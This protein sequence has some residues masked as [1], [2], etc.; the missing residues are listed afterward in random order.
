MSYLNRIASLYIILFAC[1]AVYAHA[2]ENTRLFVPSQASAATFNIPAVPG[3][4]YGTIDQAAAK[5]I[6]AQQ[7]VQVVKVPLSDSRVVTLSLHSFSVFTP[8]AQFYAVT[9]SG[10]VSM[11]PPDI[12]LYQGTVVGDDSSIVYLALGNKIIS[13]SIVTGGRHY[14]IGML[15]A[16]AQA[17]MAYQIYDMAKVP[18][19]IIQTSCAVSDKITPPGINYKTYD[20]QNGAS[21]ELD[22]NAPVA[23]PLAVQYSVS[24]AVDVDY[25]AYQFWNND[26]ATIGQYIAS[27]FGQINT[28][29]QNEA[30]V[31]ITIS[32]FRVWETADEPY[33]VQPSGNGFDQTAIDNAIQQEAT[34][35]Q[36]NMGS[37]SRAAVMLITKKNMCGDPVNAACGLGYMEYIDGS[38]DHLGVLC[39][40]SYGYSITCVSGNPAFPQE[41]ESV[42]AHE[43]G[44]N[45]GCHHTHSCFWVDSGYSPTPVDECAPAEDGQCFSGTQ[46]SVGTIMSYCSQTNFTFGDVVGPWLKQ[47]VV[48]NQN[49]WRCMTAAKQLKAVSANIDFG[50]QPLRTPKDSTFSSFLTNTGSQSVTVS[51]MKITGADSADFAFVSGQAPPSFNLSP[52]QKRPVKL[53]F[54]P[55]ADGGRTATISI[56][57]TATTQPL[58]I[59]LQGFGGASGV[60]GGSQTPQAITLDQNFPNPV[61]SGATGFSTTI[62]YSLPSQSRIALSVYDVYG[63]TVARLVSGVVAPGVHSTVLDASA[64]PA[65]TYYY[66]LQSAGHSVMRM[67]TVVR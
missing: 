37:V 20:Q 1:I 53:S 13:G 49:I 11:P 41:D 32:Y 42:A 26:S 61:L 60:N 47:H 6:R 48:Q 59:A 63:R 66:E 64:L 43:L 25:E 23:A 8:D 56:V 15:K 57:N 7:D 34:Y 31:Q 12:S 5:N 35:W 62:Q 17:G 2:A 21:I 28:V 3:A 51:S 45:F 24:L 16:D 27:L 46:Q 19:G 10:T 52:G 39:N 29:Y 22:R 38:G 65:G 55:S 50:A 40:D 44:H 54:T 67:L 4:Q 36:D 9:K 30:D 18:P 33:T 14:E 58:T